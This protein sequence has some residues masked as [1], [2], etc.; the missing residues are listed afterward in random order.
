MFNP[1]NQAFVLL[2]ILVEGRIQHARRSQRGASAVEWVLISA[3]LIGI[4]IAVGAIILDKLT[5]KAENL[6]LG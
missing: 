1:T 6:D 5:G 2:K 3:L 4:A